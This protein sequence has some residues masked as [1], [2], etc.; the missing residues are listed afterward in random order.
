V[1]LSLDS[2]CAISL[3]LGANHCVSESFEGGKPTTGRR[4][5]CDDLHGDASSVER[6][7][8]SGGDL[9][10]QAQSEGTAVRGTR[11]AVTGADGPGDHLDR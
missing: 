11:E 5:H 1:P 10:R 2:S 9:A 3:R 7:L 8:L 6:D 4:G